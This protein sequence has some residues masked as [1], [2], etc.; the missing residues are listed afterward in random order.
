MITDRQD[1]LA[2]FTDLLEEPDLSD[3]VTIACQR[4]D[5][6]RQHPHAPKRDQHTRRGTVVRPVPVQGRRTRNGRYIEGK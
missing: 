3:N 2:F 4:F 6:S 1:Y 5:P